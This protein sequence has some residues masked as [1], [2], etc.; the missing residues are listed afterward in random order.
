MYLLSLSTFVAFWLTI[1]YLA[2][3]AWIRWVRRNADDSPS[4]WRSW[5]AMC[6][7]AASNISLLMIMLAMGGGYFS[8]EYIPD[9]LLGLLALRIALFT[10][11]AGVIAALAGT[12]PLA[13]PTAVCS[14]GSFLAL[15]IH[16]LGR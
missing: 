7:F 11:L 2:A 15:A 9:T 5:I 6:G 12:K 8:H 3:R 16:W 10:A 14:L 13:V 4:R 1:G